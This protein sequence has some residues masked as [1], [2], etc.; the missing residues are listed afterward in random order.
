MCSELQEVFSF[1][2]TMRRDGHHLL[3][4][5]FPELIPSQQQREGE[6]EKQDQ[7]RQG[8]Q[9][10]GVDMDVDGENVRGANSSGRGSL[11]PMTEQFDNDGVRDNINLNFGDDI[12]GGDDMGGGGGEGGGFNAL[13]DENEMGGILEG[14]KSPL[15]PPLA[16]ED[17]NM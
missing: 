16:L 12:M 2:T 5:P 6:E 4:L 10:D 17:D 9:G 1:T 8:L 14:E 11:L 3:L 7:E 15:L 13:N